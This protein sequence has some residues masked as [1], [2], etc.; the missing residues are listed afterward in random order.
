ME[1][2]TLPTLDWH[3]ES[4]PLPP[5]T[6]T[7][8][9]GVVLHSGECVFAIAIDA[10]GHG[11]EAAAIADEALRF[12]IQDREAEP[13]RLEAVFERCHAHLRGTRGIAMCLADI[14]P[15]AG[16]MAWLS[17]GNIQ[18]V[19]IQH[20]AGGMPR[21]ETLIMR[22]GVVGDRL[23]ELRT[24][25]ASLKSGDMIVFASDGINFGW[26]T[27]YRPGMTPRALATA[28]IERHCH[29]RDDAMAMALHYVP[30]ATGGSE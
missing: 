14:D 18:A 26:N 15:V 9:R 1:A 3:A 29:G 5:E 25:Y 13:P 2:L 16:N 24:S 30:F 28:L 10:L 19:H 22:G 27:E 17:V 8:D 4:A 7:G 6:V 11:P 12:L 23:P 20:D 21:Y